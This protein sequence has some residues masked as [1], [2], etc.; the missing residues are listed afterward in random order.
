MADRKVAV[1]AYLIKSLPARDFFVNKKAFP[2]HFQYVR[3]KN[4]YIG[5][6]HKSNKHKQEQYWYKY[7]PTRDIFYLTLFKI[8]ITLKIPELLRL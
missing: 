6:S 7:C 8:T 5:K 3:P 4:K 1:A 2:E